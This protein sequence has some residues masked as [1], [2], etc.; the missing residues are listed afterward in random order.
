[1]KDKLQQKQRLSIEM[2]NAFLESKAVKKKEVPNPLPANVFQRLPKT[3]EA[4]ALQEGK[5]LLIKNS[6]DRL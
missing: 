3:L 6:L 2:L 4:V 5:L 1:M